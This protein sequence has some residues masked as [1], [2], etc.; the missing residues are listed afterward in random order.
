MAPLRR[1]AAVGPAPRAGAPSRS[2]QARSAWLARHVLPHEPD[3]RTWLQRRKLDGLETDDIIQD[4][5]VTLAALDSVTHI[6]TPRAYAFQTAKSLMV[7]HLRR[8][9]IVQFADVDLDLLAPAV[10]EPSPETQASSREQLRRVNALIAGLPPRCR[11]AF[12]LR[13]F[14]GLSQ[15]KIAAR[16]GLSESTV[17]KHVVRALRILRSAMEA[18]EGGHLPEPRSWEP[19][20]RAE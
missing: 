17:E 1:R 5:Y 10:D 8:G 6:V 4:T 19:P 14:D 7:R 9:Q 11:E 16:M 15:R 3:L 20:A 2:F 12:C 18:G 13:R